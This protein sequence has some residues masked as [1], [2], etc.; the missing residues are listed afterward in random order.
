MRTLRVQIVRAVNGVGGVTHY[1]GD[2][3][4]LPAVLARELLRAGIVAMPVGETE[5]LVGP[6]VAG[7]N[8]FIENH[9]AAVES[10]DPAPAKRKK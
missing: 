3:V 6:L 8:G 7:E 1:P 10:R 2:V 9:A 5:P 4:E